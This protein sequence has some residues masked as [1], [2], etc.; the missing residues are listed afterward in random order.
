MARKTLDFM[1]HGDVYDQEWG[2]FFRY[3]TR[4]DWS[5]PHYEKMLE[6]NAKLLSNVLALYRITQD[7]AHAETARRTIEYL[8]WKLRDKD[9]GF[10]YGSQDADEQFYKLSKEG[11]ERAEEPYIDH[12]CYT[13]W[14]AMAISAYLEASWT[15]DRPS[16]A[17]PRPGARLP[18]ERMP[19][20]ERG[21]VPLPRRHRAARPRP[22]RRPGAHREGAARRPRGDRRLDATS[23]ARSNSRASWS[24]ASS[25]ARPAASTTSGTKSR[26][27]AASRTARSRSRTT[28]SAPK[29][30]SAST[31]SPATTTIVRSPRA[32][33]KRSRAP[34]PTW[35]TSPPATPAKS[36]RS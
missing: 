17:T 5:D 30:S 9:R 8:E 32:R 33:S 13:S 28:P 3:A 18:L 25:T 31:T 23:T 14:N 2:G 4:R 10:F 36:T 34:T 6:D 35:A 27:S 7:D 15:L 12:T 21:H 20:P 29:S 11:R 24:T 22:A 19:R 1:S 16:S 26:T